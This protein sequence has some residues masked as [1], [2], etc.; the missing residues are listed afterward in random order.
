VK[1]L[2]ASDLTKRSSNVRNF[3]ILVKFSVGSHGAAEEKREIGTS[4]K[5]VQ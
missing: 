5:V 4:G 2:L 3:L 1:A